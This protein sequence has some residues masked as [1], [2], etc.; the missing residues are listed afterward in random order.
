LDG[1]FLQLISSGSKAKSLNNDCVGKLQL[2]RNDISQTVIEKKLEKGR[3]IAQHSSPVS[4]LKWSDKK[5]WL[6]FH[7]MGTNKE[8]R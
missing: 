8:E 7:L 1:Q 2:N 6:A 4:I 3:L 5:T